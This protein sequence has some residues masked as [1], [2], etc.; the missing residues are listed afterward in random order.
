MW[1]RRGEMSAGKRPDDAVRSTSVRGK[2]T[3]QPN[4]VGTGGDPQ[5]P[6][7]V[8]VVVTYNRLHL[9]RKTL[10]GIATGRQVPDRVVLVDNA[11]TDGTAEFLDGLG[12]D[13]L[14][15]DIVR[16]SENL[17]GA[18]GFTAGIDRALSVHD[19]DLVWVMDDDTEPLPDTLAESVRAWTEYSE[20]PEE[21]PAFVASHV[22]WTDGREHPMNSMIERIG[23]SRGRKDR[24]AAVGGRTIRSGSFVSLLMD[25]A[26]MRRVGLPNACYFIWNDDFEYSTRLARFRDAISLPSSVVVHHTKTFGTTDA[27]P[28][29]RFYNDVRN[30]LWVFTR[31]QSL[32]PWEKFLYAGATARLWIRTFRGS[33][34]RVALTK[35]LGS[36]VADALKA[37]RTNAEVFDGIYDL[38]THSVVGSAPSTENQAHPEDEGFS[39]LMPVYHADTPEALRRAFASN[40]W[41]QTLVP[42]EVVIVV[43]GPVAADLEQ[44]ISD[45]ADEAGRRGLSTKVVPLRRNGGLAN[46]LNVGLAACSHRIVAR[47]DADDESV[48][49]RF[50][51]MVP[52]VREGRYDALGSAM[53][54]MDESLSEVQSVRQVETDP[55]AIR[56]AA[57]LRNPLCHPTVVFDAGDVR[58]VGGYETI[59]GAEDYGLWVRMMEGGYTVGNLAEPLVRYRAGAASWGRRGGLSAAMR[60]VELQRHLRAYGFIGPVRWTRNVVVRGSYRLVPRRWRVRIYRAVIG[61]RGTNLGVPR[62]GRIMQSSS[63][64]G[65]DEASQ[66]GNHPE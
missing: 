48:P 34:H 11:S 39:L 50:A 15:L 1:G 64:L 5:R 54:E 4:S 25:A 65:N 7:V 31:S 10:S 61:Q 24:A 52:Q 18:G 30:K 59:P 2:E 17:G 32:A 46:A 42:H 38:D 9:L 36:G 53:Y 33:A 66:E 3:V 26:A 35:R 55:G 27:D 19:A 45:V 62:D 43:D 44:T 40:T 6:R 21:R 16:L 56:R 8:A 29:P 63:A 58:A 12:D 51:L 60:E 41:E 20:A 14:R 47:A 13:A 28:G 23:A 37:P 49:E 57:A 22:V